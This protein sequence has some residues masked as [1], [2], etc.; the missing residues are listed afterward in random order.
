M[1][2]G[3]VIRYTRQMPAA[4]APTG[5]GS[6]QRPGAGTDVV[7]LL[8][9]GHR[10]AVPASIVAEVVRAVALTP[11]AEAPRAVEGIFSLRGT[12]VPTIDVRARFGIPSVPLD[13]SHHFI[14]VRAGIR[15]V[16]LRVDRA[17]ALTTLN[18]E[19][20]EPAQASVPSVEHVAGVALLDDGLIVIYDIDAFLSHAEAERLESL[21]DPDTDTNTDTDTTPLATPVTPERSA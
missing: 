17:E 14:V 15:L 8:L 12:V 13:P 3:D 1:V 5:D 6:L 20:I 7:V 16:A 11:L 2:C 4:D 9:E 19:R 21:L 18:T 10:Y